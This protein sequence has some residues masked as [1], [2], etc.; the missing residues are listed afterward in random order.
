M[1]RSK[2]E[3][4]TFRALGSNTTMRRAESCEWFAL[5]VRRRHEKVV[6]Y[7]LASKGLEQLLP[8]YTIRHRWSDRHRDL[9]VPLFPG[10]VFCR[11]PHE[12]RVP[13]LR[14]PGVVSIVSF[15]GVLVPVTETEIDSLRTLIASGLPLAPWPH[16][17]VGQKVSIGCGSLRG[18]EGIVVRLKGRW[19]VVV[20]INLLQR[21]VAVEIDRDV[22]SGCIP[23]A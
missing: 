3:A 18:V 17:R 20:N 11:F 14:T 21:S 9:Q 13:V 22:I 4:C 8:L 16:L 7:G 19:R 6:A 23:G 2:P 15:G 10:Y 12:K 1:G 5:R